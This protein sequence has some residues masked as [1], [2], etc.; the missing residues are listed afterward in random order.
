MYHPALTKFF[1]FPFNLCWRTLTVPWEQ[2][3]HLSSHSLFF[4]V[5]AVQSP[6]LT[7]CWYNVATLQKDLFAKNRA[8][9]KWCLW[10]A[11]MV[12][13]LLPEDSF[14]E[15][16]GHINMSTWRGSISLPTWGQFVW[17]WLLGWWWWGWSFCPTGAP[18]NNLKQVTQINH[19]L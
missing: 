19:R 8:L 10:C 16:E 11:A 17:P 15:D 14:Q 4:G 18:R 6:S 7:P 1:F 2:L 13:L 5:A 3:L 9:Y 12:L